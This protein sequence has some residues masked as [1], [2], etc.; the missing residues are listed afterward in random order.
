[1]PSLRGSQRIFCKFSRISDREGSGILAEK[2]I[3]DEKYDSQFPIIG[4]SWR[5]LAGPGAK[6]GGR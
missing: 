5:Q 4:Y 1:M 2:A 6:S 3:F